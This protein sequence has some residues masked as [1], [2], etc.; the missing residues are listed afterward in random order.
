M[1]EQA[2]NEKTRA[3][4]W[5]P[6][7]AVALDSMPPSEGPRYRSLLE[8]LKQ[9]MSKYPRKG[10]DWQYWYPMERA[11]KVIQNGDRTFYRWDSG[12]VKANP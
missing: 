4:P 12:Q 11:I 3:S 8:P 6:R 9:A 1:L 10:W 7:A 2:T 5:H